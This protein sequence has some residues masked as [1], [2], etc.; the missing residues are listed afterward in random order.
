MSQKLALKLYNSKCY[1]LLGQPEISYI[2]NTRKDSSLTNEN[3]QIRLKNLDKKFVIE[4]LPDQFT[5]IYLNRLMN[6]KKTFSPFYQ[7]KYFW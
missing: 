4:N 7:K 2:R 3:L 1:Y 6:I 5:F